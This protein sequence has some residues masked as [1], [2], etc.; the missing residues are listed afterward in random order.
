MVLSLLPIINMEAESISINGPSQQGY[1]DRSQ[2]LKTAGCEGPIRRCKILHSA[3][4]LYKY[5]V[6]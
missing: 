6:V 3:R 4:L 5:A 2:S 1:K